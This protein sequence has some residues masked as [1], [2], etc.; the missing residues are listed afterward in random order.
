MSEP[1][2]QI[3]H[4]PVETPMKTL[5]QHLH[6]A[7]R[8]VA[9]A[10]DEMGI[11]QVLMDFAAS[12]EIDAARLLVFPDRAEG[13]P[14]AIELREAWSCDKR[15]AKRYGTRL[16]L[17][18]FPLLEAANAE[19][20]MI[21]ENAN[22]QEHLSFL[23]ADSWTEARL[24]SFALI[25]LTARRRI[26]TDR[27]DS[28]SSP[29]AKETVGLL[30]IARD[31]PSKYD[32]DLIYAFWSLASQA[33]SMMQSVRLHHET[34]QRL[35]EMSV[36]FESSADLSSSLE[37]ETVLQTTARRITS[38]LA[39]DGCAVSAWDREN[40]TLTTM[41][42]YSI[43]EDWN[44]EP[45]GTVYILSDYPAS[46][47]VLI[48]R[49]PSVIH[50]SDPEAD[51]A[52]VEWMVQGGIRSVLM[53]PMI[54]RDEAVSLLELQHRDEERVFTST[55]I[56]LCQTLA[57][58][59]AAAIENARLFEQ[60][61]RR[62]I[63]LQTGADVSRATSSILD[64]EMLLQQ[65]VDLVR[66][67]FELYYA[68]LFLVDESGE[69]A[70]LRAGTGQVGRKQIGQEHK[71]RVGND[72][73]V[74]WCVANGKARIA[75]DV[76][77]ESTRYA[78][79]LLPL[80]RSEL[81]MP[82]ITR[83]TVIGAMTIQSA[84]TAAFSEGDISAFQT[85]ADQLANAIGN[86]RLYA[87]T[88]RRTEE[89]RALYTTAATVNRSLHV[90]DLL[91]D[92]LAAVLSITHFDCGLVSLYRE[93]VQ[94]LRLVA[95]N[96]LPDSMAQ[97]FEQQGLEGTLCEVVFNEGE[98]L[99][100]SDVR[101]G[102]TPVDVRGLLLNGLFAYI[103]IPLVHQDRILGTLCLFD[104]SVRDIDTSI[105]SLLEAIGHQI[106]VGVRNAQLFQDRQQ[107][108]SDLSIIQDTTSHLSTTLDLEDAT[109]TLLPQ[110]ASAVR[111]Q[112]VSLF[113][114]RQDWITRVGSYSTDANL[115][116]QVGQTLRLADY[117][118]IKEVVETGKALV[119]LADDPRLQEH[120][121]QAFQISGV[122][123]NATIPLVGREGVM[124]TLAVSL[125]EP[126]R[127]FSEHEI[128]L[129]QTLAEQA[130]VVFERIRLFEQT[131]ATADE[132]SMLFNVSQK[133]ASGSMQAPAI[134]ETVVSQLLMFGEMECSISLLESD[135]DTLTVIADLYLEHDG[136]IRHEDSRES[137]SLLDY[138]ATAH[139][140]A[141]L[142]PVVIQANEPHADR[143]ELGYMREHNVETL[144]I[145]PLS[146]KGEAIG[147]LQL[148]SWKGIQYTKEQ[149]SLIA[150][151][152]N[153]AAGALENARLL[154]ELKMRAR[155]EEH[156]RQV[157]V[158]LT[159]REDLLEN[160]PAIAEELGQLVPVDALAI[161]SYTHGDSEFSIISIWPEAARGSRAGR[162]L[163]SSLKGSTIG[164]V[165]T[166]N[167][168]QIV[169]DQSSD[170]IFPVDGL[171]GAGRIA[172]G[173]VL[174]LRIGK[175]VIG[176]LNL[177]SQQPGAYGEDQLQ[178]LMQVAEQMALALERT[179]LLQETREALTEV[180]AI[181][182]RYVRDQWKQVLDT[183]PNAIWGY[184]DALDGLTP[185]N[186][187]WT[188]EME[189]AISSGEPKTVKRT[190]NGS[191]HTGHSGLAVPI[192][193]LGQTIGVLDF[194]DEEREWT[195]NDKALV[196][197]LADRVALALEKQRL[198]EQTQR[199][200]HREH[201]A[202]E[203]V[204]KI[205]S[206]GDADGVLE[207]A[208][209]ELGIALGIS[210]PRIRLVDK[211]AGSGPNSDTNDFVA[212]AGSRGEDDD[213]ET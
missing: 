59:A 45:S 65:V 40:D 96:G 95:F 94:R 73:M 164:R 33:A 190:A 108:L 142:R 174:P 107:Q 144:V 110:V 54:V 145:C 182:Q 90:Q 129:L 168:P 133:L 55:E 79:L 21:C 84:E 62:T 128:R 37:V 4:V 205:R 204:R 58:Q 171:V 163:R 5:L 197:A 93:D 208:A 28:P 179:R 71:L 102:G 196:E 138:P 167:L 81:A 22:I 68:G 195:E 88:S 207:T 99:G 152:A 53:V 6:S 61:R 123:A 3:R 124:G 150:T 63:Q 180:Q 122:S 176:T 34:R 105:L 42:D 60:T 41:I 173:V 70:V 51:A 203:I 17:T 12:T 201:L 157:I 16:Q 134:A 103:G 23:G 153:Q 158:T 192:R 155:R 194:Y 111:A 76:G 80:T 36:L 186:A 120:S 127:G 172:S 183:Y 130:T 141:T 149:L 109:A 159:A 72:S 213:H 100:I 151:L 212:A 154:E 77:Q 147:I 52:E 69:W 75:H 86:A 74:G 49:L 184:V 113:F 13:S 50:V 19:S 188:P 137:S 139:A 161:T 83:G 169:T 35:T 48:S 47:R 189:W 15:P 78:N 26:I 156:L 2:H 98:T 32:D 43:L 211:D 82:L 85:M 148:E 160:I 198:F 200:A 140:M 92:V 146:V 11:G 185:V 38:A 170:E 193:L 116:A 67:R 115:K 119:V 162:M 126:G 209:E 210:R 181:H 18:D 118:L 27:L 112:T 117:P 125:Y 97:L 14:R 175:R 101:A 39:A 177:A 29:P 8:Q 165:I 7:S 187:A 206:A 121:R 46:R 104:H 24:G 136:T 178:V 9:A 131:Q 31:R 199:R 10:K 56:A 20:S 166:H 89:L 135:G 1:T 91:E 106:G 64:L 57:N 66:D 202:A 44:P 114:V 30:V 191:E 25:P 87:E 143:S 132:L